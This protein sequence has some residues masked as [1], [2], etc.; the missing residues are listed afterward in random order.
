MHT[1]SRRY[2]INRN[3]K[4]FFKVFMEAAKVK[5]AGIGRKINEKINIALLGIF[6][7]SHGAN[8]PQVSK[9]WV[10]PHNFQDFFPVGV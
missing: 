6:S 3:A 2:D 10:S 5:K 7:T 1:A 8:H 4:K 9:P